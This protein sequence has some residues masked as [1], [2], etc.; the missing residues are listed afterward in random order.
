MSILTDRKSI[1]KYNPNVKISHEE[2]NEI[3]NKTSRAPSSMNMQPWRFFVIESPQAK[4]KLR[5][6]LYGN[7]LQL[8]TSSAMI[9]IMSDLEK[10]ELTETIFQQAYDAHLM[11]KEVMDR[12]IRNISNMAN[13]LTK[14]AI[15]KSNLIDCGLAAM[16][17]ML[18]AKEH[19]YDTCPIGGFKHDQIHQV[20]GIDPNR[21][22]PVMIVSI[23]KADED[24]YTSL[25]LDLEHTTS[26]L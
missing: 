1:R 23:G 10:Y 3:L 2:M 4:E 19:G 6:I 16:Q 8:D 7:Q 11:P 13:R 14:E 5:P 15:S 20:L 9:V 24:G 21:Y 26:Y 12:Q 18:V 17:L 25:R 22:E